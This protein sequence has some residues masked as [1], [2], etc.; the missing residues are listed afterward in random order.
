MTKTFCD[1]CE[2]EVGKNGSEEIVALT[3]SGRSSIIF[4]ARVEVKVRT[5]T[6][7]GD[8]CLQC[9]YRLLEERKELG[10]YNG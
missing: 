6:V 2:K 7:K 4:E 8:L 3:F 5:S 1:H 9:L 10:D